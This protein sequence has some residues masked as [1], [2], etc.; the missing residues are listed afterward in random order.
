M[1]PQ[2]KTR[3]KPGDKVRCITSKVSQ[4]KFGEIYT[5]E[6]EKLYES[7]VVEGGR[8]VALVALKEVYDGSWGWYSHHFELLKPK[9]LQEMSCTEFSEH[10]MRME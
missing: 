6:Y 4:Y 8:N 10:L 9:P 7:E 2:Y 1:E 5:V 3:F